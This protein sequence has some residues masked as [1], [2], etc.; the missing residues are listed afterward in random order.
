MA[1]SLSKDLVWNSSYYSECWW[2]CCDDCM[3]YVHHWVARTA[4]AIVACI[5]GP[6]AGRPPTRGAYNTLASDFSCGSD[7]LYMNQL[8]VIVLTDF[9]PARR[10]AQRGLCDSDVSVCL[11]V[12]CLSVRAI[13]R[14]TLLQQQQWYGASVISKN[15]ACSAPT[16]CACWQYTQLKAGPHAYAPTNYETGMGT[17][18]RFWRIFDP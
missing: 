4:A 14:S 9:S 13:N 1:T 8:R 15:A 10:Y 7:R 5:S 16:F 3:V 17:N 2:T 18:W 11:S 6:D 12:A